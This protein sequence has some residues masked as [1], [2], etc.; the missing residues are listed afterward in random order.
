MYHKFL[1]A[2]RTRCAGRTITQGPTHSR[3]LVSAALLYYA[4]AEG[5]E[6]S[7]QNLFA[8]SAARRGSVPSQQQ[9][10]TPPEK[11]DERL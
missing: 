9:T 7:P 4:A 11:Q 10:G 1:A 2:T 5:D 3:M 6:M 8:F